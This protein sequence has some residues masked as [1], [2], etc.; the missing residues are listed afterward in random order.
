MAKAPEFGV[1]A[2]DLGTT[3]YSGY[4][5]QGIVD[6][7]K[8]TSTAADFEAISNVGNL[9]VEG[10]KAYD[11]YQ[12]LK[13]VAETVGD[14][15]REQEERSLGGQQS[16][17]QE[18]QSLQQQMQ[19]QQNALG[20]D[21]TYPTALNADLTNATRGIQNS[22]AEKT[23]KLTK[24]R[25]QGVM[26]DYEMEERLKK[27][28][29]EAIARN[30][31]YAQE[32]SSHV[33]NVA[34]MNNL[35]AR[36]K[37]DADVITANQKAAAAE[38]KRLLNL[39]ESKDYQIDIYGPQFQN[40]DGTRNDA[41]I[42]E[43]VS[44]R[45]QKLNQ[46]RLIDETVKGNTN[47]FKINAQ[48]WVAG[49]YQWKTNEVSILGAKNR[50]EDILQNPTTKRVDKMAQIQQIKGEILA[51]NRKFYSMKQI[52]NNDPEI[53]AAHTRLANQLTVLEEAALE[54]DLTGK[55]GS[56]AFKTLIENM[57]NE[58]KFDLYDKTPG[59]AEDMLMFEI[60]KDINFPMETFG[61]MSEIAGRLNVAINKTETSHSDP[62]KAKKIAKDFQPEAG[63]PG[64]KSIRTL[65]TDA[66]IKNAYTTKG[67]YEKVN[68]EF[69]KS[70]NSYE[71]TE[72]LDK[73]Y[74]VQSIVKSINNP[75]MDATVMKNLDGDTLGKAKN[76]IAEYTQGPTKSALMDFT[77]NNPD[78]KFEIRES[79][80]KMIVLN[81]TK[82]TAR[83]T[84][85]ELRSINENFNAYHNV[86]GN[87]NIDKSIEEFYGLVYGE[88]PTEPTGVPPEKK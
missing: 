13:G 14:V 15:I 32:I 77:K 60:L 52:P 11:E 10:I 64:N 6:K 24:A 69:N 84:A 53:E 82:A 70:L 30:P 81:P 41:L 56:E 16:L 31:A 71:V 54:G 5:Q 46:D 78:V 20:Y 61:Q 47:K 67:N 7:G 83:F 23:D 63:M 76:M 1:G 42:R 85:N 35:T 2:T 45:T 62:L 4:V 8:A 18:T 33:V 55:R 3:N 36:I 68:E 44:E 39:A 59:L 28:T 34:E 12:T 9:A 66:A 79:D 25:E 27:I 50:I 65:I 58:K 40:A 49:G 51:R 17:F 22:L 86:S 38:E 19:D 57:I 75:A 74:V 73:A 43:A 87:N 29:R 80:G 21:G 72:G 37:E 48:E 26:D 88:Q